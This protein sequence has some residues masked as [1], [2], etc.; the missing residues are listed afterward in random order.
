VFS[1]GTVNRYDDDDDDGAVFGVEFRRRSGA[2]SL[3]LERFYAMLVKHAIHWWRN[4]RVTFVQLLLPAIFTV[5]ACVIIHT[6]PIKETDPPPLRL[7]LGHFNRPKV[8]FT[9]GSE[10]E[11]QQLAQSYS[12]VA[13]RHGQSVNA[14]GRNMDDYLLAIA[15][16]SLDDYR[17]RYETVKLLCN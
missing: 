2:T 12:V 10:P 1:S 17:R 4:R 16:R 7:D 13:D 8:P 11:S 3:A 5:I 15:D 14:E 9:A 6:V